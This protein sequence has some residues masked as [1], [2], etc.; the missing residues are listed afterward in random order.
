ML[1]VQRELPH[2]RVGCWAISATSVKTQG[3]MAGRFFWCDLFYAIFYNVESH[4]NATTA[5]SRTDSKRCCC[6][7]LHSKYL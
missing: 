1:F 2:T 7:R 3:R 4:K 5:N 6:T